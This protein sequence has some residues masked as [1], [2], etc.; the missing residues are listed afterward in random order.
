M[1]PRA[2]KKS[3]F[4]CLTFADGE[5]AELLG[6]RYFSVYWMIQRGK[7]RACRVVRG[8]PLAIRGS[9]SGYCT[10]R[11]CRSSKGAFLRMA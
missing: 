10:A 9:T 7:L 3:T 1:L 6:V 2:A 8:K 4:Q 11:R 5:Q